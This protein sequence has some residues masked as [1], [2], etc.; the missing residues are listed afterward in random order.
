MA[1]EV[2]SFQIK[3]D[4]SSISVII[5]DKILSKGIVIPLVVPVLDF[6]IIKGLTPGTCGY[7]L[8]TKNHHIEFYMDLVIF[9]IIITDRATDIRTLLYN[10]IWGEEFSLEF[11]DF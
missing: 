7:K 10:H 3:T 5:T 4:N 8:V 6:E 11:N 9:G 2:G 1:N